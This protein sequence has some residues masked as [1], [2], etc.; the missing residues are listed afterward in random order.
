MKTIEK[1][2][3]REKWIAHNDRYVGKFI[4]IDK[5]KRLSKQYHNKKHETLYLLGGLCTFEIGDRTITLEATTDDEEKT[6]VIEPKVPHRF[7]ALTDV[8]LLEF[9]TPELDDV[10]RLEDDYGRVK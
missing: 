5:G 8:I 7:T 1:P 6:F 9:S 3:G 10:V 4:F 2:W